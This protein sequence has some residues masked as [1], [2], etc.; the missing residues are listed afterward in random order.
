[1]PVLRGIYPC[2]RNSEVWWLNG[3][4]TPVVPICWRRSGDTVSIDHRTVW[5]LRPAGSGDSLAGLIEQSG[6]VP[7]C[8]PMIRVHLGAE[9]DSERRLLSSGDYDRLIFVSRNALAG[10]KSILGSWPSDLLQKPVYAPGAITGSALRQE[11]FVDVTEAADDGGSEALL[12][13]RAFTGERLV[14]LKVLIVRGQDGREWLR[15]QLLD[16]KAS[17]VDYAAVYRREKLTCDDGE[18]N[19]FY[20]KHP[21]DHVVGHSA[22]ALTQLW[23]Q[24]PEAWRQ[25]LSRADVVV[26][27]E[28]LRRH[29]RTLG[30]A[31]RIGVAADAS[32][33]SCLAALI[34]H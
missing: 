20:Q 6:G 16:G 27:S 28:R 23:Q 29:A 18:M 9:K 25:R 14:G 13:M 10:A 12:P 26:L 21:P 3:Y 5:I 34:N 32:D 1:M 19:E 15:D 4:C 33:N 30:F 2:R 11:G 7:V 17:C 8:V 31:G 22:S 24:T